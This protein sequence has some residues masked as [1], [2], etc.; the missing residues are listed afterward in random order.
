MKN[1]FT[2]DN[3]KTKQ[4]IQERIDFLESRQKDGVQV[5]DTLVLLRWAL[6]ASVDDMH[7]ELVNSVTNP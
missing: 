6:I 2:S 7:E 5:K 3:M 1:H 4:Q